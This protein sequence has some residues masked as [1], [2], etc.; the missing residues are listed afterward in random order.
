VTRESTS[1]V[2]PRGQNVTTIAS[3]IHSLLSL[4]T[5][6]MYFPHVGLW[7][8]PQS[9]SENTPARLRS[10]GKLTRLITPSER[11]HQ[12]QSKLSTSTNLSHTCGLV[13]AMMRLATPVRTYKRPVKFSSASCHAVGCFLTGR[14]ASVAPAVHGWLPRPGRP[15]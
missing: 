8:G 3:P 10:C 14:F 6:S 2:R 11:G 12:G 15:S 13:W 7:A 1:V 9:G 4:G 5:W